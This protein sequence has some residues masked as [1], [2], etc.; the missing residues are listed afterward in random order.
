M[1]ERPNLFSFGTGE[2][3]QDA[4]LCWLLKWADVR[5]AAVDARMHQ[6]GRGLVEAMFASAGVAAPEA[7][8]VDLGRQVKD[9]DIVARLGA[10]H[11]LAIE[12]KVHSREHSNQLERYAA[13]LAGDYSQQTVVRIYL[14]TGDE[15]G[16][17]ASRRNGW[18]TFS[19]A[20]LLAVLRTGEDL[21]NDVLREFTAHLEGIED[22]VNAY[23]TLSPDQWKHHAWRGFFLDLQ[24]RL[25][26]G[27][28]DYVPNPN[29]GFMGFWWGWREVP[30]GRVYL[31]L[32][33]ERLVLKVEAGQGQSRSAVRDRLVSQVANGMLG[34]LGSRFE[35]PA[36]LGH[37]AYMAFARHKGDYRATRPDGLLLDMEATLARL[38]ELQGAVD[39]LAK[40]QGPARE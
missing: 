9:I 32:E 23:R 7:C 15:S 20:Q 21:D 36:R 6:L 17:A 38:R 5:N 40:S 4:A 10:S 16:Y 14:K 31:Q 18:A 1:S 12:D 11:V 22:A 35:R 33:E 8:T 37:G 39:L 28:W 30:G 13:D 24:A 27:D 19:R 34:D 25:G 26:D 2:L 29:G 3:T